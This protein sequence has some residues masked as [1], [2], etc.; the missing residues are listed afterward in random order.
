ML[1]ILNNPASRLKITDIENYQLNFRPASSLSQPNGN[2]YL[3]IRTGKLPKKR[4]ERANITF[5]GIASR[6]IA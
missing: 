3:S 1:P 2:N 5:V 4:I 6:T